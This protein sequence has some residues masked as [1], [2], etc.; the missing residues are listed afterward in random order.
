MKFFLTSFSVTKESNPTKVNIGFLVP[1]PLSEKKEAWMAER[2]I[3]R[4]DVNFE[5]EV[6]SGKCKSRIS[7]RDN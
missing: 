3:K 4:A 1:R 7:D 6:R 2:K 5:K